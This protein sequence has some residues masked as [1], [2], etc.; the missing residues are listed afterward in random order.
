M[1]GAFR[2]AVIADIPLLVHWSFSLILLW[3]LYIGFSL[4]T[5][6]EG[7]LWM[8]A[9]VLALFFCVVLHEYGHA[10]TARRFSVPTKDIILFPVGGVARLTRLPE[11]PWEEFKI[12]IAGPLVNAVLA[13][14]FGLV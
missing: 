7:I 13:I 3:I 6:W 12:A 10:L 9:L 14:L 1:K 2:I 8:I 11:N 4:N 5:A